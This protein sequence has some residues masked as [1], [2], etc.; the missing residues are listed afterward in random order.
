M[1]L[2]VNISGL[3]M[4]R[5]RTFP[6]LSTAVVWLDSANFR[7]QFITISSRITAPLIESPEF[8]SATD[9]IQFVPVNDPI[10]HRV[11]FNI[12]F[13]VDAI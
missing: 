3:S 4:A 2:L 12:P 6:P 10:L 9:M 7:L 5:H 11:E 13:L 1:L 8:Q